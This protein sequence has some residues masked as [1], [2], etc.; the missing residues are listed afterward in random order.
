MKPLNQ[1]YQK[2][3]EEFKKH[4]AME[5]L[6]GIELTAIATG[7]AEEY[8]GETITDWLTTLLLEAQEREDKRPDHPTRWA[9]EEMTKKE[10][11]IYVQGMYDLMMMVGCDGHCKNYDPLFFEGDVAHSY[12]LELDDGGRHHSYVTP[13]WV[14][15]KAL[16]E[17]AQTLKEEW[18]IPGWNRY[19]ANNVQKQIKEI[20]ALSTP[21]K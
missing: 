18:E 16:L 20:E 7:R 11:E 19:F 14:A 3:I 21:K 1:H 8:A 12:V 13:Q 5:R 17:F 15:L 6:E 10:A 9:G 2:K 4:P